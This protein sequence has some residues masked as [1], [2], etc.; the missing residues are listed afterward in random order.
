MRED[1]FRQQYYQEIE[2]KAVR[3]MIDKQSAR[4]ADIEQTLQKRERKNRDLNPSTL[5]EIL[6]FQLLKKK[7]FYS[8]LQKR[9][10]QVISGCESTFAT[11]LHQTRTREIEIAL[12]ELSN[13]IG[14]A[15]TLLEDI[16][17]RK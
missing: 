13:V 3:K 14:K 15:S 17:R 12:L 2:S 4:L 6:E 5:L 16:K 7:Q 8:G 10:E 9:L 11:L 1:L